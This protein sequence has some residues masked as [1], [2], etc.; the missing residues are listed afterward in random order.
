MNCQLVSIATST[1][2]GQI[3]YGGSDLV[4]ELLTGN[5][6]NILQKVTRS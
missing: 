3:D 1:G 5:E 2:N 4:K 6:G